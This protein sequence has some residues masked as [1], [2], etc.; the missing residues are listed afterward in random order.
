MKLS[1]N[2]IGKISS[3]AIEMNGIQEQKKC[4]TFE[5]CQQV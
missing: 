4:L 5:I 1:L 3:A 2:Y